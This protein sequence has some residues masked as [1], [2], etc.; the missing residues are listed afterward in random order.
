MKEMCNLT[1]LSRASLC[2]RRVGGKKEKEESED[3]EGILTAI[4]RSPLLLLSFTDNLTGDNDDD[5]D[6]GDQ[7]HL[8][9]QCPHHDS[10]PLSAPPT[11]SLVDAFA[12]PV[13]CASDPMVDARLTS[14]RARVARAHLKQHHR[15][16]TELFPL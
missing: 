4:H 14:L 8:L 2:I 16:D 12:D 11:P 15:L 7:R 5:S 6:G 10:Q 9:H 1:L 13:T 3:G